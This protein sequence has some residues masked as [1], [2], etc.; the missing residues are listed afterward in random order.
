MFGYNY[1]DAASSSTQ[2]YNTNDPV[3]PLKADQKLTT[4]QWFGR[5]H[6]GLPPKTGDFMELPA[7]GTYKGELACNRADSK[8][9]D[10]RR[11]DA[12]PIHA[13]GGEGALHVVNN[14]FNSTKG[15]NTTWFGGTALAIAYT[16]DITKVKPSDMTVISVNTV[17]PWYRNTDYKIPAGLPACPS[18]GCLCTWNWIHQANHG[19]GYPYEIYN[20]MYRCKVT[21][22]GTGKVVGKPQPAKLCAGSSS[23]CVKGPKQPNYVWMAD[24]NNQAY[25][26][27]PP[28]YNSRYGFV[29]GAQTDIFVTAT[30]SSASSSKAASTLK[31]STSSSRA[32]TST[33]KAVTSSSKAATSPSKAASTTS[34][35]ATS[36]SRASTSTAKPSTSTAKAS[37]SSSK[38]PVASASST[39]AKR[40]QV[41]KELP[42]GMDRL[43]T[44]P[45]DWVASLPSYT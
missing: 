20:N 7:G 22:P 38:A 3:I 39:K 33:S 25:T 10:P 42:M 17:S 14:L 35:A 19:E 13:C 31:T 9:R 26:E 44:H 30:S 18:G 40:G 32:A 27:D 21:N 2:N 37:P 43:R 5:G 23:T 4:A 24:G 36:T 29:E 16:S 28:T 34:K 15:L 41:S 8:L 11:T 1:P 45:R 6:L 12:Q